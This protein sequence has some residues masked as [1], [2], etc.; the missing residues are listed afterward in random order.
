MVKTL[1]TWNL[2]RVMEAHN[3]TASDLAKKN[4]R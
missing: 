3:I 2:V 4:G 1:I